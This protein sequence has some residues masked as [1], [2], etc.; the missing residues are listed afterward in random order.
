ML[1]VKAPV[2]RVFGTVSG[3]CFAS[4]HSPGPRCRPLVA[5]V[6]TRKNGG[7]FVQ[8]ERWLGEFDALFLRRNHA[9]PIIVLPW[10]VWSRLLD[11]VRRAQ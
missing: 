3:A 4:S 1:G 11:R 9:D 2:T 10:R 5:E 7:G 8:L 6:K